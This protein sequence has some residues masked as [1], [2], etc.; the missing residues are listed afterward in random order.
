MAH[1]RR[2]NLNALSRDVFGTAQ[3]GSMQGSFTFGVRQALPQPATALRERG[4]LRTTRNE[5]LATSV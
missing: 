5:L 4:T 1:G 3:V 2:V